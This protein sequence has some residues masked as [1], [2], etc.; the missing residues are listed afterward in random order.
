[1]IPKSLTIS[2]PKIIKKR[3]Y[4][5]DV[6]ETI[7]NYLNIQVNHERESISFKKLIEKNIDV[8]KNRII[9]GDC[10]LMFQAVK[11]TMIIK[12]NWKLC[13]NNGKFSLFNLNQDPLEKNDIKEKH[14][15]TYNELYRFYLRTELKAYEIIKITLNSI[16]NRSILPS[17]K[18]K[19]I[20][21]PNQYPPHIVKFLKEKLQGKNNILELSNLTNP[22]SSNSQNIRTILIYNRLTGYGLKKLYKK[23]Q[24]YTKKFIILDTHLNDYTNQLNRTGYF[25]FVM[26]AIYARRMQL[27]QRW[28]EIIVWIL[29]FPLYFNKHVRKYYN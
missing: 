8:N 13:N 18:S 27:F 4:L 15:E 22:T 20:L 25:K 2:L 23:Y 14:Q 5:L 29:Y 26:R 11:R 9:R 24:K 19:K 21:I 10:Y 3:V 6:M 17:L 1:K 12:D 16:Y 28:K 7:L